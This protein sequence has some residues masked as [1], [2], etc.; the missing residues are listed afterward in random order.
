MK[1]AYSGSA[2][3]VGLLFLLKRRQCTAKNCSWE[4]TLPGEHIKVCHCVFLKECSVTERIGYVRMRLG[5][6]KC[7]IMSMM[8][9]EYCEKENIPFK[10]I[11]LHGAPSYQPNV[12][13]KYSS[14]IL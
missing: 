10:I 2:C 8:C 4:A 13:L 9:S 14:F 7:K 11:I 6:K 3:S 1:Q 5:S 12:T